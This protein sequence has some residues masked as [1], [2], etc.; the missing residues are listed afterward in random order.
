[1]SISRYVWL[2]TS[3]FREKAPNDA[4][5]SH[6]HDFVFVDYDPQLHMF[7]MN[8]KTS[9]YQLDVLHK[10][11]S[12]VLSKDNEQDFKQKTFQ[13]VTNLKFRD[14]HYYMHMNTIRQLIGWDFNCSKERNIICHTSPKIHLFA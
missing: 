5:S 1:M 3:T 8:H 14:N 11:I 12:N 6:M 10:T 7:K 2:T 9:V 13:E 4:R